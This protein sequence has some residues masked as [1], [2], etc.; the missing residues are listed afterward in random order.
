MDPLVDQK[1]YSY[2]YYGEEIS[3]DVDWNRYYARAFDIINEYC[4]YYFDRH[5]IDDLPLAEDV[6]HVKKAICAQ[7]EYFIEL[8]GTN[9]LTDRNQS[10]SSVTV[11]KFTMGR[12]GVTPKT[13]ITSVTSQVALR[14]LRPTGLLYRGLHREH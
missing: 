4:D 5:S 9:E 1:Y 6:T 3:N 2:T 13:G 7:I 12:S 14:Y 11:G 8:G 10:T